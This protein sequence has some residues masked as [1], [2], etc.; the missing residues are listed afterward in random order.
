VIS[1]LNSFDFASAG[2]SCWL[3]GDMKWLNA[4]QGIMAA[5]SF[6]FV[7]NAN[8][9]EMIRTQEFNNVVHSMTTTISS[10]DSASQR[11]LVNPSMSGR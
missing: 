11:R 1:A 3:G 4:V 8:G 9:G 5:S 10:I 7:P 6:F 2:F